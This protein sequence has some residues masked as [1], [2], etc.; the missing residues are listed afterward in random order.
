MKVRSTLDQNKASTGTPGIV[1]LLAKITQYIH[2]QI[3]GLPAPP[4]NCHSIDPEFLKRGKT[5]SA[6]L[7]VAWEPNPQGGQA[8]AGFPHLG[9]GPAVRDTK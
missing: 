1:A 9:H 6:D 8:Q 5:F 4:T 2:V 7:G 3:C